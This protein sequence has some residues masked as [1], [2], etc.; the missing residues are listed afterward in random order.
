VQLLKA[1]DE[2]YRAF[3]VRD[4]IFDCKFPANTKVN[5]LFKLHPLRRERWH[6]DN[7]MPAIRRRTFWMH[8]IQAQRTRNAAATEGLIPRQCADFNCYFRPRQATGTN[9]WPNF[10]QHP[11]AQHVIPKIQ[12]ERHPE[13]GGITRVKQNF[14]QQA[15]DF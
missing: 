14:I 11:D 8:R 10:W 9:S 6:V 5:G 13:L 1:N 4:K 12:W 7:V 2:V 15:N 3:M